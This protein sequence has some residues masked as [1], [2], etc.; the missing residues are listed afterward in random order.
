MKHSFLKDIL[1][2]R[3]SIRP[4]E[5]RG[6]SIWS[7]FSFGEK[8]IALILITI[9]IISGL[10]L[11]LKV[12]NAFLIEV[13]EYGG[14]YTEGVIGTPRFINPLLAISDADKDLTSLVY[15]GLL[16]ATPDGELTGDLAKEWRVSNDGLTYT[17]IVKD[18]A[19]FHNG[20]RVTADDVEFTIQKA[21]D[22][23]LKSPRRSNWEG[24]TVK[25]INDKEISFVLRQ[26]YAPFI[27]NTTL[28]ILPKHIWK[29]A[30]SDEFAFSENN[31]S[32]IGSGPYKVSKIKKSSAGLPI[33]FELL[34]FHDYLLGRPFIDKINIRIYQ[35]E[36]ELIENWQAKTIDGI[37]GIS[38]E[39]IATLGLDGFDLYNASLPRI[40]GVFFNQNQA[41]IFLHKE[42]REAL[43]MAVNKDE[44]IRSTLFGYGTVT[45]S[46]LP[47]F[48]SEEN[49]E[50][51]FN[52]EDSIN[53]LEK[54]GWKLNEQGIRT[55]KTE[56]LS[57]SISTSD[58][59]ELKKTAELLASSWKKLGVQVEIKIFESGDLNQNIIRPR[60]YDAL[61]FGIV[62]GRDTDLYP[63]WH[64]S[65][66]NDPGLNIALYA[67]IATDKILEQL[68]TITDKTKRLELYKSFE[69]EIKKDTPA[70]LL[71]SPDFMY[72]LPNKIQKISL[73][74]IMNAGERFLNVHEWFIETNKVW[75]IFVENKKE[76]ESELP[77][78][79]KPQS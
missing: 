2:K 66:R 22:P 9:F 13:P 29:N 23:L 3:F 38:A 33:S 17:F 70:V 40:F 50:P 57:F 21:I 55:K 67:N 72:I 60:K 36:Q 42:V 48:V 31:L 46:P 15:S 63:F 7:S 53:L 32:P 16:K 35:N 74:H 27:E 61:L 11:L 47:V 20:E 69:A 68:R 10:G 71:Y 1:L 37:S 79:I 24:V 41:T 62:V 75:K 4:L 39:K 28:G 8:S 54:N 25:K 59:P 77:R 19:F 76:S 12:S 5:K 51:I 56:E 6:G 44:I 45:E 65:Q 18:D 30:N 64:S 52:L 34:S 73:G 78:D 14:S 49:G 26:P 58:A 43:N